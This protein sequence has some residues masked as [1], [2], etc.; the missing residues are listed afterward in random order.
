MM[1]G[2]G[3]SKR[4]AA[5]GG[6]LSGILSRLRGDRRGVGAIEFAFIAPVMIVLYIGAVEVSVAMSAN[7]K[8]AR[9]SS[10]IADLI[11]QGGQT[12]KSELTKM[13]NVGSSVMAPYDPAP[14]AIRVTG[15]E[16]DAN[17]VAR[18]KWSWK[19][20][21]GTGER[22]YVNGA[23]INIPNN[24]R[25]PNSFLVRS[26]VDYRHDMITSFPITGKT[27]TG[28]D[29][30]KTYHLRPRVGSEVTCTNC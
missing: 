6:R 12:D 11:T 16:I 28:I 4:A 27:M 2:H 25:V 17:G 8:L 7:K 18:I 30:S 10:T 21:N 29:M 3:S 5:G 13:V 9:A 22:A 23:E 24:F 14:L 26:E 20:N 19:P 15:I 1:R